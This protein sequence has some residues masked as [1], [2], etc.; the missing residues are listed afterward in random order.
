MKRRRPLGSR[1]MA[2]LSIVC[3][4]AQGRVIGREGRL[5]WHIPADLAN[6]KRL[7]W[8]KVV[9]MGRKTWDSLGRPLP[10]RTNVVLS[11]EPHFQA[12][13]AT[14][15]PSLMEAI[16]AYREEE[17]IFLIGGAQLISQALPLVQRQYLSLIQHPFAGDTFTPSSP[18]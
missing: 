15:F 12:P 3:A 2:R 13:G 1:L 4:L 18:P 14:V 8:G 11:R 9:V 16:E 6:F 17:E 7:T 5:P 10:Q